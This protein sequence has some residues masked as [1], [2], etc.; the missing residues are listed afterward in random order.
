M[1][2]APGKVKRAVL[3]RLPSNVSSTFYNSGVDDSIPC[4]GGV[5][6]NILP[7]SIYR[8]LITLTNS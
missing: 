4:G 2:T 8:T 7:C 1:A 6:P 3:E 5:A